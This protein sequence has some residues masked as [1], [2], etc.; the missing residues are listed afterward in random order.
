[1]STVHHGPQSRRADSSTDTPRLRYTRV[2]MVLHWTVAVMIAINIVLIWIV[3]LIPEGFV[4]P[5][6][7]T[8]KSLGITVMGLVL[9]HL[10]W[11]AAN[12]PPALPAAYPSWERRIAKIAHVTMYTLILA[13]PLSGWL[14]DSAW[15]AAAQVPMK[16]FY[17]FEWPRIG[18][19]MN[20]D[21][22]TK[23]TFHKLTG[24]I[25]RLVV[26]CLLW[27]VCSSCYRR[28][29]ASVLGSPAAASAHG[30]MG[31]NRQGQ[32]GS[33]NIALHHRQPR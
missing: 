32:A 29:E 1:M 22:A 27:S 14:H 19:V 25:S 13:L 16:L 26:V 3:E 31:Q 7:D 15:K 24:R 6:I 33:L 20:L 4:R 12:P 5:A 28:A 9:L 21:P 17:L 23:E 30:A 11:R 8:H 18:F 10:L 2:A